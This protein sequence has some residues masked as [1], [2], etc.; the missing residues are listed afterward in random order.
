MK[1]VAGIVQ[2]SIAII[3]V[4]YNPHRVSLKPDP[5][6]SAVSD[7]GVW[8]WS[9]SVEYDVQFYHIW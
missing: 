7:N 4:H 8:V 1:L 3:P 2:S 6:A 5:V 9:H